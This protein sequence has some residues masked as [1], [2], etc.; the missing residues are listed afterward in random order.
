MPKRSALAI[1][2]FLAVFALAACGGD[3]D[4]NAAK[5]STPTRAAST[6]PTAKVTAA[7]DTTGSG[8][9]AKMKALSI[10][11][12]LA[13]G[14]NLGNDD[15]KV[16]LEMYEDFRC[17]HCLEFTAD[18]EQFIV[19][20]YV[21]TGKVQIQFHYFPLGQP[22]LPMM[23][24]AECANQ[25]DQFW[26]YAKKLFLVQAESYEGGPALQEGFSEAK[27]K[28]YAA[29]LG[30]D[31]TKYAA[32]YAADAPLDAVAADYKAVQ[33]LSLQG[34]PAFVLNGKLLPENPANNATWKSILDAAAK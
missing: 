34:T 18:F 1:L 11:P 19:D 13:K 7:K 29:A 17:I 4:A 22:S 15:A 12:E 33:A 16:K 23:V 8:Y 25:Q 9:V 30:L 20:S 27:F 2:S 6:V 28:E 26:P 3:D 24:A 31:A 10:P 5:A 14:R 21:K 32:C